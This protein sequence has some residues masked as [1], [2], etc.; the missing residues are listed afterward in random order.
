MLTEQAS[1][2][3]LSDRLKLQTQREE[4]VQFTNTLDKW[5]HQRVE[6]VFLALV[7]ID[8]VITAI[9]AY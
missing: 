2:T 4:S 1:A 5:Y 7:A 9:K 6:K 3:D 8:A